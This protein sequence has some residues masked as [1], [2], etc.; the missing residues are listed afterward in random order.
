[1]Q[2]TRLTLVSGRTAT[3]QRRI[4]LATECGG[5]PC[6]GRGIFPG[7]ARLRPPPGR[8]LLGAKN[9]YESRLAV[10]RS[11]SCCR[12]L[13]ATATGLQPLYR[14]VR[15]DRSQIGKSAARHLTIGD[16]GGVTGSVVGAP[17]ACSRVLGREKIWNPPR[18]VYNRG[19][20][21]EPTLSRCAT[22][23]RG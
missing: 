9:R 23:V 19:A 18:R 13:R 12:S 11:A 1:M 22:Y 21:T 6:C 7:G 17:N 16:V 10:A 8:P 14:G 5:R 3:H 15:H 4:D 20:I 2:S